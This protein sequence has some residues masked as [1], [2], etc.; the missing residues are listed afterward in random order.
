[1]LE[2]VIGEMAFRDGLNEFMEK[3]AVPPTSKFTRRASFY[4]KQYVRIDRIIIKSEKFE[5]LQFI[6]K[7]MV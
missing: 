6:Y 2:S 5:S 1:M 3:K 7:F 4:K